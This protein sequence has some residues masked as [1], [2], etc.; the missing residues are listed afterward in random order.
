L[1]LPFVVRLLPLL[2]RGSILLLLLLIRILLLCHA[3]LGLKLP[4]QLLPLSPVTW[5]PMLLLV[6]TSF[7]LIFL[8]VLLLLLLPLT[9]LLNVAFLQ[10]LQPS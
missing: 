2:M 1:L 5:P 10:L 3:L 9:L 4:L 6:Q 8:Q 7:S